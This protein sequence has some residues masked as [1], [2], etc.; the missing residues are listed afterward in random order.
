MSS[1]PRGAPPGWKP[2]PLLYS[3]QRIILRLVITRPGISAQTIGDAYCP[4]LSPFEREAAAY[5]ELVQLSRANLVQG[6]RNRWSPS[7]MAAEVLERAER[8]ARQGAPVRPA[9]LA[10]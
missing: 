4:T 9:R 3:W 6:H 10:A 7:L 5:H 1:H 8:Q 2:P